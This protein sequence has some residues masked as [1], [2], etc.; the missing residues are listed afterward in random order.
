[1]SLIQEA[2]RRQQDEMDDN[3]GTPSQGAPKTPPPSPQEAPKIARKVSIGSAPADLDTSA[4]PP[5]QQPPEVEDDELPP[6]PPDEAMEDTG[7]AAAAPP[8]ADSKAGMKVAMLI[9]GALVCLGLGV[10]AVTFA[11]KSFKKPA[12]TETAGPADPQPIAATPPENPTVPVAEPVQ[13]PDPP[14]ADPVPADPVVVTAPP[15]PEPVVVE[16]EPVIWPALMVSGLVGKG[17]QGS[18]MFD[19]GIIHVGET[20]EGIRVLGISHSGAE[21]EYMGEKKTVKVGSSTDR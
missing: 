3:A 9:V 11:I 20:I 15:D 16:K 18:V 13:P 4:P 8:S 1:M 6:P 7:G 19:A 12:V 5:V 21:L 2:L 10:W 14:V 17:K